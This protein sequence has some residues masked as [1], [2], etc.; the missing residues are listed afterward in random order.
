MLNLSDCNS[1]PQDCDHHYNC[2]HSHHSQQQYIHGPMSPPPPLLPLSFDLPLHLHLLPSSPLSP[3]FQLPSRA[4]RHLP[5]NFSNS[6]ASTMMMMMMMMGKLALTYAKEGERTF[7][8]RVCGNTSCVPA[9]VSVRL[10]CGFTRVSLLL[11][12]RLYSTFK[13][14]SILNFL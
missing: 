3:P 4:P 12:A 9:G 1:H 10:S 2:H 8:A 6:N 11:I 5:L 13:F 7:E 14:F